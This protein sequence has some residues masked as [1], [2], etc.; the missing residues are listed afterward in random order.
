MSECSEVP[1]GSIAVGEL[2][3]LQFDERRT[4]N[5]ALD[6]VGNAVGAVVTLLYWGITPR[7]YPVLLKTSERK[8]TKVGAARNYGDSPWKR[9]ALPLLP[10]SASLNFL[11]CQYFAKTLFIIKLNLFSGSIAHSDFHQPSIFYPPRLYS[12][13]VRYYAPHH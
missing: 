13:K 9:K 8:Y 3:T 12:A 5:V 10:R 2:T 6:S 11:G 7:K 1:L 4:T